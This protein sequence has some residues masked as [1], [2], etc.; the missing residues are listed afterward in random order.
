MIIEALGDF[1]FPEIAH[2]VIQKYH[3]NPQAR[4][5]PFTVHPTRELIELTIC[6]NYAFVKRAKKGHK[7][8]VSINYLEKIQMPHLASIYGA[9]LA[10]VNYVTM[11]AGIP[12]G[13]PAVFDA[14]AE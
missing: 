8:P 3:Q 4:L 11:G 7:N 6:A 2:R 13:I 1:P 5:L 14:Y 12:L 10:D 9:M